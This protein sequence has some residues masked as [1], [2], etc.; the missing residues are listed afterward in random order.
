MWQFI[1]LEP[2]QG[3]LADRLKRATGLRLR[4]IKKIGTLAHALTHRKYRYVV[5]M[6]QA[7]DDNPSRGQW[8]DEDRLS[9]YPLPKP[10]VAA[11]AMFPNPPEDEHETRSRD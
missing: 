6:A 2:G 5:Y 11:T 1:T 8:V 4:S 7:A 10:H 3:L 9:N